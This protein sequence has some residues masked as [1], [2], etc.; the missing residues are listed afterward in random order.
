MEM[1]QYERI[2]S[3]LKSKNVPI[4]CAEYDEQAFGS[5]YIQIEFS[6]P[7]RIAHDGRDK[8]IVLE[9]KKKNEWNCLLFDKTKSGR[10]VLGKLGELLNDL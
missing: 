7:L 8:T 5:W 4:S 10:H 6:P 3:E 2:L 1:R 9:E